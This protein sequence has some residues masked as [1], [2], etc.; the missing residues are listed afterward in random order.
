MGRADADILRD[1]IFQQYRGDE[2][3]SKRQ[4]SGVQSHLAWI[5]RE[6][7]ADN[8]ITRLIKIA[9]NVQTISYIDMFL[10]RNCPL[11][12]TLRLFFASAKNANKTENRT[13]DSGDA[14]DGTADAGDAGNFLVDTAADD[15]DALDD[16]QDDGDVTDD[17]STEDSQS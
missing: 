17:A 4:W 16:A 1:V 7:K 8:P 2:N 5:S 11:V 6:R 13:G 12:A 9:K 14:P 15:G 3:P 10:L